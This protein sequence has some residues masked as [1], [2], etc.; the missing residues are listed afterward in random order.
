MAAEPITIVEI[1]VD[2]CSLTFGTSPCMAALLG[3]VARKCFNTWATCRDRENFDHVPARFTL[4]FCEARSSLPKGATYFPVLKSFSEHSATVN[5]AGSDPDLGPLGARATVK[6]QLSDFPYHDR[7]TDPYQAERISGDAQIDEP[8]YDPAKRGTFFGKLRARWPYFATRPLRVINAE[9][10]GGQIVRPV[11][12]HYVITDM[13]GPDSDGGVSFEAADVLDLAKNE[14]AVAPKTSNGTISADLTIDGTSLTLTPEGIGDKEYLSSGRALLGSEI[15]SYTRSG[16]SVTLTGRGVAKTTASAHSA[17]ASFQQVLH[18]QN[19]RMDAAIKMLLVDYANV[20]EAFIPWDKWEAE[21]DR[22]M[23]DVLLNTHITKPTGVA[24]LIGELLILGVS[25]WWDSANQEIGLKTN[26]PPAGDVVWK[27]SDRANIKRIEQ[28]ARDEK[29]LTKILFS[30]VQSDP[31]K[32]GKEN[33]DRLFVTPDLAAEAPRAYNGSRIREIQCRWLDQG[34]DD[35]VRVLSQ[36]LLARFKDAP[37]HYTI[38]LDAKDSAIGL[39]DILE[40]TT[41]V[42]EGETGREVVALMQVR[43]RSEPRPGHEIRIVAEAYEFSARFSNIG[44]DD[45]PDYE[46]AEAADKTNF[47][48]IGAD[49][50]PA[51]A[52]QEDYYRIV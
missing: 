18:V 20:P 39:T 43:E 1:D 31:T 3:S 17:G 8:G 48:F 46:D 5:I 7:L 22:W 9:I 47:G 25:I 26:R 37:T 2:G 29:R 36:R 16:D 30:T 14:R 41:A 50:P 44:P 23:P 15:V 21:I 13:E 24:T 42:S 33:F 10:E 11:T 27:I 40:V 6:V 12:R 35:L 51:F 52:D 34:A 32:S 28:K 4:R 38:L 49:S 45:L 19:M